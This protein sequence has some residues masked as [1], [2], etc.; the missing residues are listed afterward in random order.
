MTDSMTFNLECDY[1]YKSIEVL[2]L[3]HTLF[4][5]LP[6]AAIIEGNTLGRFF[7]THGG[8]SPELSRIEDYNEINRFV[9]P[10][11][12]GSLCDILWSDPLEEPQHP[13]TMEK[14]RLDAWLATDFADNHLRQTSVLYGPRGLTEFL[15]QNDL[16]CVVRAH[17]VMQDG[18]KLHYFLQNADMPPCI[19]VF[20][21]P[22][23]CDMYK[24]RGAILKINKEDICFEQ[25]ESVDHPF[26]LP[27]FFDAF[28][29][30]LPTMMEVVVNI[31][32]ELVV[33]VK[34]EDEASM[35]EEDKR[36]DENLKQKVHLYIEKTTKQNEA[37]KQMIELKR[38]IRLNEKSLCC[39]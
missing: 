20:S 17:Q 9:E 21:A 22:N 12:K 30:S 24:N 29:Y 4:Q 31:L 11:V 25:F 8:I 19:T 23:Y 15:N 35:T 10:P 26:N 36:S 27:D 39:I 33:S 18:F 34:E 3:F 37:N 7:C 2:K 6:L 16:I 13:E 28:S 32:S 14:K 38:Q 1:K 5:T